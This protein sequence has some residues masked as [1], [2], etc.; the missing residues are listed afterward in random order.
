MND[1]WVEYLKSI[2]INDL[3]INR[4]KDVFTF[5]ESLC[6]DIED[7]FVTDYIDQNDKR[8]YENL[9][10]F[11]STRMFEAKSFITE[12]DFDAAI[13]NRNVD[14]WK[15]KK[16]DYD[17]KSASSKSRIYLEAVLTNTN[18]CALKACCNNCDILKYIFNKYI[19]G[20]MSD[21]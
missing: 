15:I 1:E 8:Q 20:Q 5:Y 3:L 7:I 16:T 14:Y 13:L 12:D 19:L 18:E 10:F 17:F 11:S 21:L 4:I 9:W 6:P 2:D